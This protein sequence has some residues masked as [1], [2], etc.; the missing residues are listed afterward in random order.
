MNMKNNIKNILFIFLLICILY[1]VHNN[2]TQSIDK[3]NKL[4]LDNKLFKKLILL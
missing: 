2:K 3:S 1:Y 4:D